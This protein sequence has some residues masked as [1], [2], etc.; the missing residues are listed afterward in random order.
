[1]SKHS[2]FNVPA[3]LYSSPYHDFGVL[4]ARR[5]VMLR[6]ICKHPQ[7]CR[8]NKTPKLQRHHIF[9]AATKTTFGSRREH[10]H[11]RPKRSSRARRARALHPPDG[12]E[13]VKINVSK[14]GRFEWFVQFANKHNLAL[15][16]WTNFK[17]YQTDISGDEMDED[18]YK[19]YDKDF[20][21]RAREWRHGFRRL[22]RKYDLPEKCVFV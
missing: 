11:R 19:Q 21:D 20:D 14:D 12:A 22:C 8:V 15:V 17:G 4:V 18:R 6:K 7:T 1:M 10:P 2:Y 13:D 16:T 3:S 9:P 5:S